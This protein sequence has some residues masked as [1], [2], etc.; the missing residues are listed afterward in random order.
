MD[1]NY[2]LPVVLQILGILMVFLEILVPSAGLISII[3]ISLFGSSLYLAFSE[4]PAPA[5]MIF[6]SADILIIPVLIYFGLKLMAYS[7]ITLRKTLSSADGVNSQDKD[8]EHFSG[9]TG[10][11]KTDLRPAGSAIIDNQRVDVVSQGNYINKNSTIEVVRI[12]GN[13]I[14]VRGK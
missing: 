2:T 9:K 10:I 13:Q 4:L 8:M 6:L 11:A 3:A 1:N 14:I 5:G 7:P 12:T